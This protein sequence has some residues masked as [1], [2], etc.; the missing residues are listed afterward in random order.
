VTSVRRVF[1]AGTIQGASNGLVIPT[2]VSSVFPDAECFDP[3]LPVMHQL[4]TPETAAAVKAVLEA[5]PVILQTGDLGPEAQQLRST[6]VD[7][8]EEAA[9]CDLCIAYLPGST[10]SMGTAMEMY[11]ARRAGVPVVA[12]TRMTGNLAVVAVSTVIAPDLDSLR[13]ALMI[14]RDGI[15]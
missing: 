2:I 15:T 7:M 12:V 3:S 5:G 11:A 9:R 14:V 6:F 8:T 13:D 10:P 4:A 1:V